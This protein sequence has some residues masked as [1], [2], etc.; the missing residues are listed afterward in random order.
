M[1]KDVMEKIREQL[2]FIRIREYATLV[3]S[4]EL[5][6]E[7]AVKHLQMSVEEFESW[8]GTW[9]FIRDCLEEGKEGKEGKDDDD[10]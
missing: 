10:H 4:G 3:L 9:Q 8:L 6:R 7:S 5:S 1:A 2:R